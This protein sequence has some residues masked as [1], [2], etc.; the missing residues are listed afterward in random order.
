M[1][2]RGS[3][4]CKGSEAETWLTGNSKENVARCD[5]KGYIFNMNLIF[6]SEEKSRNTY[7]KK[8]KMGSILQMTLPIII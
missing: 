5:Q 3:C 8:K 4:R 1:P 6:S 2:D 7:L